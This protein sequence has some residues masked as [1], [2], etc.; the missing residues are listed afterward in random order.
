VQHL[1]SCRIHCGTILWSFGMCCRYD[2]HLHDVIGCDGTGRH[3][4]RHSSRHSNI[5]F[6]LMYRYVI[7]TN[8]SGVLG[9]MLIFHADCAE[10]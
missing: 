10:C 6:Q 7:T 5:S 9:L 4:H 3:R 1:Q 2:V 8:M